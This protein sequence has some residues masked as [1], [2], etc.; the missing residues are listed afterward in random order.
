MTPISNPVHD[1]VSAPSRELTAKPS[2]TANRGLAFIPNQGEPA[3]ETTLV[4]NPALD[5]A[6]IYG[7]A[8]VSSADQ[9]DDRQVLGLRQAGVKP[10]N[11]YTDRL[12]GKDFDRPAYLSLIG[13][14]APGDLLIV[15]SIDRLGRDYAE[16]Q[17]QWRHL[18]RE[19][20]VNI[21]VIDMPLLDTRR[22]RDLMGT[23]IADLVLQILSFVAQNEREGIRRRQSDGIAAARLRGVRFGRPP[24]PLPENYQQLVIDWR[25]GRLSLDELLQACQFSRATLYRRLRG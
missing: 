7:Y 2:D 17:E 4:S 6:S 10:R 8:R 21:A 20:E 3:Y 15:Q 12:S 14:L 25:R 16:I 13:V 24:K 22:D 11:I 9:N 19:L 5:S 18:T 23:F 1:C